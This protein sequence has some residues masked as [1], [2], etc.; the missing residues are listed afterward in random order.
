VAHPLPPCVLLPFLCRHRAHERGGYAL[1]PPLS[2]PLHASSHLIA[3]EW[4]AQEGVP[5]W[6]LFACKES[7]PEGH[8]KSVS[9]LSACPSGVPPP[10]CALSAPCPHACHPPCTQSR[11]K[12]LHANGD[13]MGDHTPLPP[14]TATWAWVTCKWEEGGALNRSSPPVC[15]LSKQVRGAQTWRVHP[16]PL[17][18][19]AGQHT[20]KGCV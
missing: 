14:P 2:A 7:A 16:L 10:P 11:G 4:E 6:P 13:G 17:A 9:L 15:A 8:A 1:P 19:H 5:S 12:Q 18:L 3:L 20:N